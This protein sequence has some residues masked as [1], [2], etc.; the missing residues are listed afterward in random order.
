MLYLCPEQRRPRPHEPAGDAPP[1]Q[2]AGA[3]RVGRGR[4]GL[5]RHRPRDVPPAHAGPRPG[6]RGP[7]DPGVPPPLICSDTDFARNICGDSAVYI[8]PHNIK[9][10]AEMISSITG[11][12]LKQKALVSEG[13]VLLSK[14]P[15]AS[16]K[17]EKIF[18]TLK[19]V[20]S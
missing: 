12:I 1:D 17:F 11:D 6:R 20:I 18:L 19:R 8:D 2:P 13:K 15:D 4:D 10:A 3:P 14:L 9:V 16:E 7:S 5:R